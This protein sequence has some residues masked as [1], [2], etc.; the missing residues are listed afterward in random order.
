MPID[1]VIREFQ[2]EDLPA[3]RNLILNAENFGE[4]FLES[5]MLI[6]RRDSIPDFGIVYVATMKNKIV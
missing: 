6:L 5:E 1:L 2:R 4:P 3:L